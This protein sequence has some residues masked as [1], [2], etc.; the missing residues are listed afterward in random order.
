M[1]F[2]SMS[3]SLKMKNCVYSES[4]SVMNHQTN[5]VNK[6]KLKIKLQTLKIVPETLK[7]AEIFFFF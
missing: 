5:N 2:N 7:Q 3:F 6:R 4:A 1:Y